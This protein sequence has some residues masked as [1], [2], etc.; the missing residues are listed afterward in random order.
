MKNNAWINDLD[1]EANPP[2]SVDL[3][4]QLVTL[5]TVVRDIQLNEDPDQITY[6]FTS[7][8]QYSASSAYQAPWGTKQDFHLS[9]LESLDTGEMQIP[10]MAS[11]PKQG[12]DLR[13]ARD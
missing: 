5:W 7:H 2:I 12:L 3:I 10:R 6:K 9:H 4:G 1:L 13:P 11:H 8:G